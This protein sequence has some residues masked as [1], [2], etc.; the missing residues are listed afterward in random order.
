MHKLTRQSVPTF[1]FLVALL[2]AGCPDTHGTGPADS[3]VDGGG[4]DT[5]GD[6][7]AD[8]PPSADA[9]PDAGAYV[10]SCEPMRAAL[11]PCGTHCRAEL[12]AF[13]DGSQCVPYCEECV[14]EDCG[15][16]A[17]VEACQLDHSNC[18]ATLCSET[19]GDWFNIPALCGHHVC[20][21][22]N[23]ADCFAPTRGCNCGTGRNFQAGVGC[24]VDVSC[25]AVDPVVDEEASCLATGGRWDVST[26]GHYNCGRRSP[27]ECVSP[28]CD[29]G[30]SRS[31]DG[32]L[33]CI[34]R[35]A[36]QAR[37]LGEGCGGSESA[38]AEGVCCSIG[39]DSGEMQCATPMC[40]SPAGVCGPAR[41]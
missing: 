32:A 26:C 17:S 10:A 29:C 16:Y 24:M 27:L 18:D 22:P 13:W 4:R 33:G 38:C 37:R 1:T 11:D 2:T 5:G 40:E 35:G 39:G 28:G 41:P 20:G 14:G 19:A 9:R 6:P 31:F 34:E 36:C 12:G 21:V 23:P 8:A 7:A 3:G 25:P 30:P 15:V